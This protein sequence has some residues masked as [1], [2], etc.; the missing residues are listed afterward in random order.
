MVEG[1]LLRDLSGKSAGDLTSG[2]I[3]A[4]ARGSEI[5]KKICINSGGAKIRDPDGLCRADC[6]E[7]LDMSQASEQAVGSRFASELVLIP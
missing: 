6:L 5:G 2:K 3:T 1:K 7:K 4:P